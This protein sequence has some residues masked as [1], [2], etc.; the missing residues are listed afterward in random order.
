[1][2]VSGGQL[3]MKEVFLKKMNLYAI[4]R[5]WYDVIFQIWYEFANVYMHEML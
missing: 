4:N 1:M 3:Y 2:G 5:F